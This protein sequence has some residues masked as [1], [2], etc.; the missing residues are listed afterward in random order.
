MVIVELAIWY[1][2][3]DGTITILKRAFRRERVWEAHNDHLY[4]RLAKTGLPHSVVCL[5][6]LIPGAATVCV[7]LVFFDPVEKGQ[8]IAV[9]LL[10]FVFVSY[11]RWARYRGWQPA[12]RS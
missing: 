2:L 10:A 8:W 11:E 9:L 5:V 12:G 1:F 6:L 4:Q 3:A 7:S